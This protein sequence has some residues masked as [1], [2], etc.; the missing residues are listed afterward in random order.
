MNTR[1]LAILLSVLSVAAAITFV[2]IAV[3][4]LAAPAELDYIEGVMM[5]HVARLAR[6]ESIYVAPSLSFVALAYMPGIAWASSWLAMLFGPAL[7]EP[8]LVSLLATLGLAAILWTIVRRETNSPTYGLAAAGLYL[9]G[10]GTAGGGHYIVSRPDSLMLCLAFG[11]L[12]VLRFKEGALGAIWAG[13]LLTL[14]F[15]TK[16]HA[17]WFGVAALIHLILNDRPRWWIFALVWV[18]GCA[19]GFLLA[20]RLIGPWFSYYV[21]DVPAHWS[22]LSPLRIQRYFGPG[23][24]GMLGPL[25]VTSLLSIGHPIRPWRGPSGLWAWA[26]LGAVG[27]GLLATL[28]PSAWHHV[29]IPSMVALSV[30][31]PISCD[32][33]AKWFAAHEARVLRRAESVMFLVLSFQFIPLIYGLHLELPHRG[34]AQARDEFLTRLRALPGDVMVVDHGFYGSRA[35]RPATLQII[36]I[37]DLERS[38]GNRLVRREPHAL[39]RIFDPLRGGSHRPALVTDDYLAKEG[40]L[41]AAL[42]SAYQLS[43]SLGFTAPL[44]GLHGHTGAPRYV[45]LPVE[46]A[47]AEAETT[48][49]SAP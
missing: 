35:G 16:Q 8:R 42:S 17:V 11:G 48:R 9:M 37:G 22:E 26:A 21:W 13:L 25:S 10:F 20:S 40:P 39:E 23:L 18:V 1:P 34:A 36:A 41:W 27:T 19:G 28:D 3:I 2:V 12:A 38:H 24:F 15:F 32:R 31:G 30:L 43:D 44:G 49:T 33:L 6:G 4:Q 45:Y 29:F 46:P 47:R 14:A 7:W 5:D